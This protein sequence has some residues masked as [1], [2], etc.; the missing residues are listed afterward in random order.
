MAHVKSTAHLHNDAPAQEG[1]CVVEERGAS[2]KSHGHSR[3]VE[4]SGLDRMS[5]N[6]G[7]S[8]ITARRIQEMTEQG[9]FAKG[10]ARAPGEENIPKLE[11][12]EVVIFK[13]FFTAGLRMPP[14]PVFADI[15]LKF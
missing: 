6:F 7:P 15:L 3:L 14:H 8:T 11:D 10:G 4:G 9:C 2:G 13:E 5:Y 12:D 1:K